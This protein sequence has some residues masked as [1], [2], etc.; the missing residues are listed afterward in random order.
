MWIRYWDS[1]LNFIIIIIL[2]FTVYRDNDSEVT[3]NFKE[4]KGGYAPFS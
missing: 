1:N 4:E 2:Y 3:G